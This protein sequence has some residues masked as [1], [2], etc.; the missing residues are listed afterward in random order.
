MKKSKG[1]LTLNKKTIAKLTGL[2][3]NYINGGDGGKGLEPPSRPVN[4]CGNPTK[5]ES[6]CFCGVKSLEVGCERETNLPGCTKTLFVT[7]K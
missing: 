2:E 4:I 3:A 6:V 7:C 1:K 5:A